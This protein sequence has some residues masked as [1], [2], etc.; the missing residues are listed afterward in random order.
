[1]EWSTAQQGSQPHAIRTAATTDEFIPIISDCQIHRWHLTAMC[2]RTA[3][4]PT[5]LKCLNIPSLK[6]QVTDIAQC[7]SIKTLRNLLNAICASLTIFHTISME[8]ILNLLTLDWIV[9]FRLF[10]SLNKCVG[11]Q[12]KYKTKYRKF[13]KELMKRFFTPKETTFRS[14]HANAGLCSCNPVYFP[15]INSV[16][17]KDIALL[18][19]G[20]EM[21]RQ[22]T[23]KDS[24]RSWISGNTWASYFEW[25]IKFKISELLVFGILD[26]W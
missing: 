22:I 14:F 1:M 12:L 3:L 2:A 6:I 13:T 5:E 21:N 4:N 24:L 19:R 18:L 8:F 11:F 20:K 15:S 7:N 9:P 26:A 17:R 16:N 23:K 10:I 25:C